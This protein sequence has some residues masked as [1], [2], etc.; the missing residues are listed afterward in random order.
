MKKLLALLF[1]LS[2]CINEFSNINKYKN[3]KKDGVWR[4]FYENGQLER[5]EFFKEDT[6]S[7]ESKHF[8]KNGQ[9][10]YQGNHRGG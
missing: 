2:S 3:G 10:V 6:L 8:N 4:Y 5:E 7:G 1:L 9:L